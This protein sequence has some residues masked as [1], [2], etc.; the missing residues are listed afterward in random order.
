MVSYPVEPSFAII[1]LE[2]MAPRWWT[3]VCSC[4][5]TS[6]CQ[7]QEQQTAGMQL[8]ADS[9]LLQDAARAPANAHWSFPECAGGFKLRTNAAPDWRGCQGSRP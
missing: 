9:T 4:S 8:C 6:S 7:K 5:G 1:C 2:A 3:C